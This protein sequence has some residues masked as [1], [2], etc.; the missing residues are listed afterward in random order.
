MDTSFFK[1][2]V[3]LLDD[4]VLLNT[5]IKRQ[6]LNHPAVAS[7]KAFDSALDLFKYKE[8]KDVDVLFLDIIMPEINGLEV[9][10]HI[11]EKLRLKKIKIFIVSSITEYR[12]VQEALQKGANGFFSKLDSFDLIVETINNFPNLD[13]K[14]ILSSS[15][16]DIILKGTFEKQITLSPR[17]HQL[18]ELICKGKTAKEI[19]FGLDLSI[20]T[21]NY[22]TKRLMA[23]MK[24]NR[25]QDLIIK[26]IEEY[27]YFPKQ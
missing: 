20:N 27:F 12:V 23:K 5:L 3:V 14:P 15:I 21:V 4:Q 11:R 24:V 16:S 25:T 13:D 2:K 18:L 6:L 19:A 7:I 1:L 17:E 22:Y 26:A 9:I 8:L 10:T